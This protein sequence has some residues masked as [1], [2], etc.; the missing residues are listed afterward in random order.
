MTKAAKDMFEGIRVILRAFTVDETRF[1]PAE[2]RIK[3]NA[4]DFQ[5]LYYLD[6]NPGCKN[7]EL[8]RHLGIPATT[9]QSV[10]DRLIR[11]GFVRRESSDSSRRAISLRLT[12]EG[13]SVVA[14]ILRQDLANCETMLQALPAN[15]R[16]QFASQILQIAS[17]LS[18]PNE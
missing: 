4:L 8:A 7:T 2:G 12:E 13:Q 15:S 11:R 10:C 16:K 3:Y 6:S 1:P 14:A 9:S 17:S 18:T 5:S